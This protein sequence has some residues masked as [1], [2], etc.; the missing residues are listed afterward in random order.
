[1]TRRLGPWVDWH[2]SYDDPSSSLSRRLDVVRG[3]LA[4]VLDETAPRPLRLLS[5]CAG[6]GRDV[7]GVLGG[8]PDADRVTARL[9]ELDPDLA[10]RA[11]ASAAAAGLP[12]VDVLTCD[13]GDPAT[14]SGGGPADVVL[15]AGVFGNVPDEDVRGTIERLPALC[16]E[17]ATVVWSRHRNPP[18]LTPAIR[19]WFADRGFEEVAFEA[20][21]DATFGVGVHR[22]TGPGGDGVLGGERL[23]T[24]FR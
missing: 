24:F 16:A 11:R 1:V 12:D 21:D 14:Y 10:D 9:V 22:W 13:A 5:I 2:A 3:H 20:P 23:F 7:L 8:R 15:A 6:D 17:G 4:R 19:G 18:D